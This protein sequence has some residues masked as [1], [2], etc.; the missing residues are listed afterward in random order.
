LGSN[1][2]YAA[3]LGNRYCKVPSSQRSILKPGAIFIKGALRASHVM[4]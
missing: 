2:G 4:P 1:C 3:D